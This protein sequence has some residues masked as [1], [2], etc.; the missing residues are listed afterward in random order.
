MGDRVFMH[1]D[2]TFIAAISACEPSRDGAKF[3][4]GFVRNGF[5]K[6]DS[7]PERELFLAEKGQFTQIDLHRFDLGGVV[8]S[9]VAE[10]RIHDGLGQ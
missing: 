8:G 1:R 4:L 9:G 6:S 7:D 5:F 3:D 2:F 10:N